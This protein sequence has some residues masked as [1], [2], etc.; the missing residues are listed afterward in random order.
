MG[1]AL[2]NKARSLVKVWMDGW[3]D[4]SSCVCFP[5]NGYIDSSGV[6]IIIIITSK[7]TVAIRVLPVPRNLRVCLSVCLS[8]GTKK[9][10]RRAGHRNC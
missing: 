6:I 9:R 5:T 3:M 1:P 4:E 7:V 2:Q 8:A 10:R